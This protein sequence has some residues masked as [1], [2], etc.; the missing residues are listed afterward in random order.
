MGY[1]RLVSANDMTLGDIYPYLGYT[2]YQSYYIQTV[3]KQ[4]TMKKHFSMVLLAITCFAITSCSSDGESE[5]VSVTL[6]EPATKNVAAKYAIGENNQ[7]QYEVTLDGTRAVMTEFELTEDNGCIIKY[8]EL[9]DSRAARD[10]KQFWNWYKFTK[11]GE[12]TF[13][14]VGFGKIIIKTK[15]GDMAY[16]SLIPDGVDEVDVITSILKP[17]LENELTNYLCRN[18]KIDQYRYLITKGTKQVGMSWKTSADGSCDLLE[19]IHEAKKH[20]VKIDENLGDKQIVNGIT[21]SANGTFLINYKNS[22][23]KDVG[24]WSWVG[25]P[26]VKNETGSFT[27][28]WYDNKMGND[29]LGGV[30]SVT[31]SGEQCDLSLNGK[32]G[33]KNDF[34][35]R[36][37]LIPND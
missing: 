7:S 8:E 37:R 17:S 29:L 6:P 21:F 23:G 22:N 24:E 36:F 30:A 33:K 20:D 32:V 27:Y 13:A 4:E 2:G 10:L 25:E 35:V 18:W 16:V 34:Q 5:S 14:I 11:E 26:D 12:N 1:F 9:A 28:Y 19:L 3:L 31:F 15:E